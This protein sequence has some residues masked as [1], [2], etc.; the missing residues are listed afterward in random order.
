MVPRYTTYAGNLSAGFT[1]VGMDVTQYQK[2]IINFWRGELIASGGS[3]AFKVTC[4]ESTDQN[5]WS[6]CGGTSE[7]TAVNEDAETQ[8]N[9]TLT[10]RWFRVRVKVEGTDPVV[11]CWA[12]GFLEDR[13]Q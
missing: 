3:P 6:V 7:D 5:S 10:K 12:V 1:T 11:S 2:A 13:Q 4:Q 9:A 8:F